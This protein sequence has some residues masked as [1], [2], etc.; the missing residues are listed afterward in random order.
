MTPAQIAAQFFNVDAGSLCVERIKNGLT[1]ESYRVTGGVENI[2]VRTSNREEVSLQINRA[3]EAIV[4]K[5]VEQAGIGATVLLNQPNNH[6]LITRELSGRNLTIEEM[7]EEKNITRIAELL[8]KLHALEVPTTIERMQLVKTLHEYWRVLGGWRDRETALLIAQESDRQTLRSLCHND[9][10]HL[11]IID[12]GNRLWLLDWEYAGIGDPYFD[13]ASMCC[14][15]DFNQQQQLML[16]EHYASIKL[17]SSLPS[18]ERDRERGRD[19]A[20]DANF[21]TLSLTLPHQGGGDKIVSSVKE[22][23]AKKVVD[24]ERLQRMCWLFDYIKELWFA[25][26]NVQP[27]KS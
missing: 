21:S 25:A 15:H 12:N 7:R 19:I 10:H 9:V 4:L 8:R 13:L 14:Y 1:N 2:V 18:W 22:E 11:N 17:A 16:L 6:V 3:S 26:R 23:W 24:V 20:R 27:V 5:L